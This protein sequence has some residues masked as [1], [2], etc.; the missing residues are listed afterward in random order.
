MVKIVYL[1]GSSYQGIYSLELLQI[2]AWHLHHYIIQ[3]GF[4]ASSGDLFNRK[5][6]KLLWLKGIELGYLCY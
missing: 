4:K 6:I 1:H 3:T 2:P 5:S